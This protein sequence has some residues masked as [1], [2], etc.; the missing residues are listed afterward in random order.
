MEDL[1]AVRK[2]RDGLDSNVRLQQY[3]R[4]IFHGRT[5]CRV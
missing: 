5:G 2:L 3:S 4:V 1:P